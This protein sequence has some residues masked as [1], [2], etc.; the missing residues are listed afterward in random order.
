MQIG[1]DFMHFQ[2]VEYKITLKKVL[3]WKYKYLSVDNFG[4][5]HSN[6]TKVDLYIVDPDG[7]VTVAECTVEYLYKI[8]QRADKNKNRTKRKT[9][10]KIFL[11]LDVKF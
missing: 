2:Q 8:K 11:S 5:S 4:S 10:V 6:D 1:K 7:S 3:E 9:V